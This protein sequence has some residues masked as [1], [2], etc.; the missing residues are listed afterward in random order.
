MSATEPGD[1][2]DSELFLAEGHPEFFF[3]FE[4][5]RNIGF[6]MT[7]NASAAEPPADSDRT[8]PNPPH[9]GWTGCLSPGFHLRLSG[10]VRPSCRHCD[11]STK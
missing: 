3:S 2:T 9:N 10:D 5:Q 4:K 11:I 7:F 8:G 6:C 1:R